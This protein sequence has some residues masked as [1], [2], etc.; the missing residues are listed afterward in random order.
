MSNKDLM[1]A[2]E[3]K[4]AILEVAIKLVGKYGSKNITRRMVATAAKV[5]EPLVTNYFG[6]TKDA[7]AVYARAAKKAGVVEPSAEKQKAIGAKLRSHDKE[8]PPVAKKQIVNP[9]VKVVAKK[10]VKTVSNKPV[11]SSISPPKKAA[12]MPKAPPLV[13]DALPPPPPLPLSGLPP[14][15]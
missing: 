7:Q 14:L 11:T 6:N 5:S 9:K 12:R 10:S 1:T 4:A 15:P 3:R 2:K 8:K 13:I